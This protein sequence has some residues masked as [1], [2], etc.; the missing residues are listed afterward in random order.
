MST[1][2]LNAQNNFSFRKDHDAMQVADLKASAD[3][4]N[5]ILGLKEIPN[6]GLPDHIRWFELA[7]KVQVHL[8]ESEE[9]I[10]KKK[11]VHM[12]INTDNLQA[13]MEH[14]EA[15]NIPFENWPGE[16]GTTNSRPD[17]IKQIYLQDPDG[18]WI[19]VNDNKF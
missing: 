9:E 5:K 15:N 8:I 3:F 2:D 10:E 14:L 18:Y 16:A 6:G 13:F 11:G 1:Q 7:D 4:Y 17:G 12:A 19:E